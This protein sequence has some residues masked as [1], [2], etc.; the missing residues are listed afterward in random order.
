MEFFSKSQPRLI[1]DDMIKDVHDALN[2]NENTVKKKPS[3]IVLDDFYK[4]FVVPNMF[5]LII[6]FI[7]FVYLCVQYVQTE[8]KKKQNKIKQKKLKQQN[9]KKIINDELQKQKEND[10]IMNDIQSFIKENEDSFVTMEDTN[11]NID[12]SSWG[13]AFTEPLNTNINNLWYGESHNP[14]SLNNATSIIFS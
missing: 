14:D 6:L 5:F 7:F 11:D 13:D 12:G 1:S 3:N 4:N 2:I 10:D 8:N 9:K